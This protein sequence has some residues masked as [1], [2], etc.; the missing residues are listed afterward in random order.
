VR[1]MVMWLERE[2]GFEE[3]REREAGVEYARANGSS[4]KSKG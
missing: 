4:G 3:K 1:V 2:R